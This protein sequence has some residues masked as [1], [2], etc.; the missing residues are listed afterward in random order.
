MC[1]E[2]SECRKYSAESRKNIMFLKTHKCGSTSVQNLL[3]RKA[4]K[5]NLNIGILRGLNLT[6]PFV[7]DMLL[8]KNRKYNVICQHLVFNEKEIEA[9]M[10][11]DTLYVSILR[12]PVTQFESLYH[13]FNM[14][15]FFNMNLSTFVYGPNTN[16]RIGEHKIGTN[17]VSYVF[18]LPIDEM[19]DSK[20]IRSRLKRIERSF[21][22]IMISEY[23]DE[24]LILLRHS[25]HWDIDDVVTFKLNERITTARADITESVANQ[26]RIVNMADQMIYE[27]FY[28]VFQQKVTEFGKEKMRREVEILRQRVKWWMEYCLEGIYDDP[29]K[30]PPSSRMIVDDVKGYKMRAILADND[31]EF[32]T[33]SEMALTE[34]WRHRQ[35]LKETIKW[36]DLQKST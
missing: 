3:F 2:K 16:E 13:Y 10:E 32:M 1:E 30:L 25:L 11:P 24:S 33:K 35:I 22:L 4:Y 6:M 12:D 34:E 15:Q 36:N 20:S 27:H 18:G 8:F 7:N 17:M 26:I 14:F 9:V 5:S 28:K 23:F 21:D 31:C 19:N 29:N